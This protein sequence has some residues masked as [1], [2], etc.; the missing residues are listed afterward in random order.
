MA[1]VK[2]FSARLNEH[3]YKLICLNKDGT[4]APKKKAVIQ[5]SDDFTRVENQEVFVGEEDRSR[6]FKVTMGAV[7]GSPKYYCTK[8]RRGKT[9]R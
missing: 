1:A 8:N 2:S 7:N 3:L 6:K 5:W 4:Q 9:I